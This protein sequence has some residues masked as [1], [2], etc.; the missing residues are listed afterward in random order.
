M[1]NPSPVSSFGGGRCFRFPLLALAALISSFAF[2]APVPIERVQE[3]AGGVASSVQVSYASGAAINIAQ[4][5][6]PMEAT[7]S[8]ITPTNS[9]DTAFYVMN[10]LI[11]KAKAGVTLVELLVVIL[12]VTILSVSMLPLLQPFVTE[13]QYAAE[14]IP[15]IG[16]LRTKIGLYQYDKGHLPTYVNNTDVQTWISGV[17]VT[18][19]DEQGQD[20]TVS[21]TELFGPAY[22]TLQADGGVGQSSAGSVMAVA[23]GN[24]AS[25]IERQI[26]INYE[27]LK[28]KR[29]KPSHYQYYAISPSNNFAYVIACF[30]DGNGL[31]AGTGYAVC[32][33]NFTSANKKYIGTWKRYKPVTDDGGALHFGTTAPGSTRATYCYIP[34]AS[35][36]SALVTGASQEGEPQIIRDMRAAGW[37]F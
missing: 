27:D 24:V 12:I 14:A 19:Q 23:A 25:H 33:L 22:Y 21:D 30:G 32:E 8:A 5:V 34:P 37:E 16:N 36:W 29:S 3:I 20:K 17:S 1:D 26:D 2:A 9:S 31:K 4:A 13:S 10:K 6:S 11:R 28:G 7:V 15:V 18:V 35:G